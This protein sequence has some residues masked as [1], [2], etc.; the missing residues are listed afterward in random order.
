[1]QDVTVTLDLNWHT[2]PLNTLFSVVNLLKC[3]HTE[4]VLF[5]NLLLRHDIS[6]GS[7]ATHLRCGEI[8]SDDIIIANLFLILTVKQIGKSVN[9]W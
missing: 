5:F 1:M 9:I 3:V 6:Q 2:K 7:V 4:V 8:F